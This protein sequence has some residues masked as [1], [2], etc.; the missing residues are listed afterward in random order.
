MSKF[1]PKFAIQIAMCSNDEYF[2]GLLAT[3]KSLIDHSS[4]DEFY[5]INILYT[6]ICEENQLKLNM[7]EKD[8]VKINFIN[9]EDK[10]SQIL[11]N[12]L[13]VSNHI[14]QEAYYRL[15]IPEIFKD[16]KKILYI[17]CDLVILKNLATLFNENIDGY[18]LGAVLNPPNKNM[19]KYRENILNVKENLYFN[20]GVM[21]INIKKFIENDIRK[22]CFELLKT[23]IKTPPCW[24]QDLLNVACYK[25]V[26]YLDS[27]W[28]LQWTP[29]IYP[30]NFSSDQIKLFR[31]NIFKAGILHYTTEKKPWNTF[32][33]YTLY[34]WYYMLKTS[35]IKDL[36]N[37]HFNLY[38]KDIYTSISVEPKC[39]ILDK[40]SIIIPIYNADKY[41]RECLESVICQTYKNIEII[42]INDGSTDNSL[43]IVKNYAEKDHRIKVLSH[44][45]SGPATTRNVGLKKATGKYIMFCDAD[46]TYAPTM[47]EDMY[48][49]INRYNVDV[50]MCDTQTNTKRYGNYF[51]GNSAGKFMLTDQEKK[52]TNIFLW[53]KIFKKSLIDDYNIDFP[54]GHKSDDNYFVRAYL[55]IA[56]SIFYLDKKLYNYFDRD[57]SIMDLYLN[58]KIEYQ[59]LS[60]KIYICNKLYQFLVNNDKLK[61]NVNFFK[62]CL[63]NEIFYAWKNVPNIWKNK[64]LE[65]CSTLLKN[66][67]IYPYCDGK[68]K[69][70]IFD[71]IKEK[72]FETATFNLDIFLRKSY[73]IRKEYS[74]QEEP[75]PQFSINN[76]PVVFN[77]DNNY[78]KYLSVVIQSIIDN[79]S[80]NNNYDI[81]ILNNGITKE[82]KEILCSMVANYDNFS[83]RFY[84]MDALAV[85]YNVNSWFTANHVNHAAYYRIFIPLIFKNFTKIIYLDSDIVL[86]TD[87][88][89]LYRE[90]LSGCSVGAIKDTWVSIVDKDNE[91]CFNGFY[92]YAK[93]V[94]NI[95]NIN[96][97][98]NSG[99]LLIDVIKFLEKEYFQQFIK[100]GEINNQYF[101]DQNI[102][103]SVLHNDL[104]LLDPLWNM[105]INQN[106]GMLLNDISDYKNAKILHFCSKF[107]PWNKSDKNL[108]DIYWWQYA[109][110]SPFYEMILKDLYN[111]NQLVVNNYTADMSVVKEMIHYSKNRFNYYRCKLLSKITLGKLR[112]HYKKKRKELKSKLKQVRKFLNGK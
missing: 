48:I 68:L 18:V 91:F 78:V 54:D 7:L 9:I 39:N 76:I 55:S 45:N 20:S 74:I 38:N 85:K 81:I 3:V 72:K 25:K 57:N 36:I 69:N 11:E 46:D 40:I 105:Q 67:K 99:V 109:R 42:C 33:I 96:K 24:D 5:V 88:A 64:F 77:C 47:C 106:D 41:L 103:N 92:N 104:K 62:I 97:Y 43:Q 15:F 31:K 56:N 34:W 51:F 13:Y 4:L 94:L 59:D 108:W 101:H 83:I 2:I 112:K 61:K 82:N 30:K 26:K 44:S 8:N 100:I 63:F 66:I 1:N 27:K 79:S 90:D 49:A 93:R 14:S 107:K 75:F 87:V 16:Y 102:L 32:N 21:L 58:G 73:M 12:Y 29:Y 6:K 28:N 52:Q 37:K 10:I 19:T 60:D 71:F 35:Y 17:D 80:I 95:T 23:K 53:N 98:F 70:I 86:Q 84:N 89:Y 50:V 110:K 22:K 65:E 111:K